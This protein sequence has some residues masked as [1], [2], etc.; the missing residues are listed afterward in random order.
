MSCDGAT[1]VC[2]AW[3]GGFDVKVC[4]HCLAWPILPAIFPESFPVKP[5]FHMRNS[6]ASCVP[7]ASVLPRLFN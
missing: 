3:P 5:V 6:D 1:R 4:Q 2:N 7:E